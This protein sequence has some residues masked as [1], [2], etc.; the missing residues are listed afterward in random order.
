VPL[1]GGW[2]AGGSAVEL[3]TKSTKIPK[4]TKRREVKI[5]IKGGEMELLYKS[6]VFAIIGCAIDVHRNLGPGFLESVY[7]EA[8]CREFL[9]R[10]IPFEA[11]KQID[12]LYKGN[13]LD[14]KFIADLVC[15]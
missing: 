1:S 13:V 9:T 14:K 7:A 11:G 4:D 10:G 5:K 15:F 12:I 2:Q 8:L 6:E 3:T